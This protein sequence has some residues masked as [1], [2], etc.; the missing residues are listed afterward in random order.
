M[1]IESTDIEGAEL[2]HLDVKNDERGSFIKPFSKTDTKM[3]RLMRNVEE[4]FYSTSSKG[5]IRGMHFQVPPF[6]QRKLVNVIEGRILDVVLDIRRNS[7]TYGKFISVQLAENDGICLYISYGLAHGFLSVSE[8]ATVLY[9]VDKKYVPQ[10][11]SGIRYDSFGFEWDLK[12]P[13]ILSKRDQS[14]IQFENFISPFGAD[15]NE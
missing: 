3:N 6:A 2:I 5:V 14:F 7:R 11:E 4:I 10:Y 13:P 8:R 1:K 12:S 15:E 9:I